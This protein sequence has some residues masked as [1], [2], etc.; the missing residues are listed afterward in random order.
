[1]KKLFKLT[2]LLLVCVLLLPLTLACGEKTDEGG[3]TA[4]TADSAATTEEITD[5]PTTAAPTTEKPTE[6]PTEPPTDPARPDAD[7][8][9][10]LPG[11]RYYLRSP[12]SNLYLQVD[13]NFK[14]AGFSQEEWTGNP[15]QMFVFESVDDTAHTYRIRALGTTAA[16]IDIAEGAAD[17]GTLLEAT[18][19]PYTENS[20]IWKLRK[21]SK[22]HYTL[23]TACSNFKGCMDVNGVSKDPGG[24]IHQWEGGTADN[25]VWYLEL[26][27]ETTQGYVAE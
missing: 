11:M 9:G 26:C 19:D 21:N 27:A 23:F 5:P 22:G 17:N 10:V 2:S 15:D 8:I 16:Y 25:Q 14:Y 3:T 7:S 4:A 18:V 24:V 6:P 20:Q 13:G 12:N 1:M